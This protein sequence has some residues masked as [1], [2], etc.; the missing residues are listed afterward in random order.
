MAEEKE[1]EEEYI[2]QMKNGAIFYLQKR[3]Q[4]EILQKK[5]LTI[6]NNLVQYLM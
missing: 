1:S 6:L 4:L 3:W 5:P 2:I